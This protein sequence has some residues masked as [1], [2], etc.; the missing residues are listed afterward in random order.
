MVTY[1]TSN[2][3]E[4]TRKLYKKAGAIP[5]RI[6][7]VPW[8][9]FLLAECARPYQLAVRKR[10]IG[11]FHFTNERSA[12]FARERDVERFYFD[13]ENR[14][15]S[16]K[17]SQ[18]ACLVDGATNGAVIRRLQERF[19]RIFIDEVQ[20]LS[21]YDLELLELMMKAGL[22]VTMI[23]DH[24]QWIYNTNPSQKN[25]AYRGIA[26]V[27]KFREWEKAGLATI[28]YKT[29]SHRCNPDIAAFADQFYP[30]DEKTVSK[31]EDRT[32]HDGVFLVR[33]TDVKAYMDRFAPQVLRLDRRTN[34]CEH[35]NPMNYGISKGKTFDRVLIFPHGLAGEWLKTG[36]FKKIEGSTP[37]MYVGVTRARFSVGFVC[38]TGCKVPGVEVWNPSA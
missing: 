13:T 36:N 18:F 15:Y 12:R 11:G 31:N 34:A 24:R 26:I 9:S 37:K 19:Q 30:K 22:P 35:L 20:D 2:V 29:D 7:V 32:G 6:E 16:D 5:A 38:D 28:T 1:T 21:G 10:R 3:E 33:S 8:F 17:V 25:S 23:G 14:I 27:D 4:I